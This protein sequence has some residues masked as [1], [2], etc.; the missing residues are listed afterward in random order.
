MQLKNALLLA[1]DDDEDVLL[2]LKMLLKPHVAEIV[3]E[4]NPE[5]LPSLL[6]KQAFDII[7]LDMNYKSALNTGNEGF[8]WL[9]KIRERNPEASVIMITAYGDV[10][11]AVK[12][13]KEGA[14]D[15]VL[16]PWH[17]AKLLETLQEACERKTAQGYGSGKAKTVA[18]PTL[19]KERAYRMIGKSEA[20]QDV[21]FKI[22]KVAPT[23]ANILILG[24]NGTGKELAARALHDQSLR[25]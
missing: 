13:L 12:S 4:R 16:K 14:V 24:E 9:K 7:L 19:R 25:G 20:M 11:L 3:T 23:D 2:A 5:K 6:G 17:N 21:L 15:F 10:E 18:K 22:E 1:V 8:F